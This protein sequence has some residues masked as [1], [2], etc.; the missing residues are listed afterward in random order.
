MLFDDIAE[1]RVE[2]MIESAK[3]IMN[4]AIEEYR[5]IVIFAGFSGGNDSIVATHFACTE[6]GAIAIHA[7]TMIGVEKSRIHA[8]SVAAKFG[9]SFEER[10]AMPAG[11]PPRHADGRPFDQ[12]TLPNGRWVDGGTAYEE[13]CFN[14]GMPGPGQHP[15]MYQ[16]LK[17]R[18]F[19]AWKRDA[20]IGQHRL[21]TVMFIT[22]I[23]HDESAIRAG[24]QRAVQKVGSSIW[25]APFYWSNKEDFEFY[26]QEFGLPR[27]PVSSVVGISGECLCGT[28]GSPDELELVAR[29]EP[30][31]TSYIRSLEAKCESLGLPCRWATRPSAKSEKAANDQQLMLFG[32][33]PEFQPACVGCIRRKQ[34]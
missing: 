11:M 19:D 20:K 6:Y 15:R 18:S 14:F 30:E 17:E 9:W 21:S 22:G 32:E 3:K 23:R 8:R 27:N 7:N 26:R 16:R 5:P 34:V 1:Q 28:M 13:Y 2:N 24:Y 4:A 33:E 29:V 12:T 10:K 31:T 25:V